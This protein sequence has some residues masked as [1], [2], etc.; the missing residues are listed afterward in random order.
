M[1]NLF[2]KRLA[3]CLRMM[4]S[5]SLSPESRVVTYRNV[6]SVD[7]GNSSNRNELTAPSSETTEP[8]TAELEL[9]E[10]EMKNDWILAAAV[11]NRVCAIAFTVILLGGTITFFALFAVHP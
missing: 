8:S 2:C 4:H 7:V 3:A 9:T 1:R 5:S 10:N 6:L 11:L